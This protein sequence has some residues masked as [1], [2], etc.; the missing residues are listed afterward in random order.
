MPPMSSTEGGGPG[1]PPSSPPGPEAPS[2][3]GPRPIV[4]PETSGPQAANPAA[5]SG[6]TPA[7][8]AASGP[9]PAAANPTAPAPSGPTAAP[10]NPAA[11]PRA[12]SDGSFSFADVIDHVPVKPF[13]ER[14]KLS[15]RRAF[16]LRIE[17]SE[18]LATERDTLL[19]ASPPIV[20]PDLQAFLAWRRSVLFLVAVFLVP[21]TVVGLGDVLRLGDVPW[22]V[23][24]VKLAPALA[25]A[26]FLGICWNQLRHWHEW[27][28]QRQ[29]LFYGWLLFLVTPFVVFVY[30]LHAVFESMAK[31]MSTKEAWL[32]MGIEGGGYKKAVQPFVFAML[33]M[34]QLA[35]KVISLMPGLIRSSMVIKLLFPGASAPGWLI[36]M[37]APLYALFVYVILVV[38]YQFT[39]SGWFMAGI[40]G[41][42]VGQILLARAGFALARPMNEADALA[43]IKRV[44]TIYLVVMF[45]SAVF[46]ITALGGLTK[47][48]QLR[49]TD[50]VTTILKFE[51][52]VLILTMI[53]A[54]LV[55]TNLDKARLYTSGRDHLEDQSEARI[56][57][58]VGLGGLPP[59]PAAPPPG[60]AKPRISGYR[61]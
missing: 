19:R 27:R 48:L 29:V 20:E 4:V 17:A 18:V 30:P 57:A 8:P 5:P 42:V 59:P 36:A 61:P 23:R 41:V 44:R 28:K 53:G 47:M 55:V 58:F 14:L 45:T 40:L 51:T 34:L 38:P 39:G 9:T 10:S 52:N 56:A 32:R 50:V 49:W 43:A 26:I 46:I 15:A 12:K 11:T 13:L 54:D 21:L 33:A 37:A 1:S 31:E 16:R 7:A 6:P 25:E 22:Q 3:S 35:P 24:M 60:P 2:T